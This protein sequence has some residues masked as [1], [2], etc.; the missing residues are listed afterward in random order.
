MSAGTRPA[1]ERLEGRTLFATAVMLDD[2]LTVTG[3][4]R[5]ANM[6]TV[7][8]SA[9]GTSVEV[10]IDLTSRRGVTRSFEA[11]FPLTVGIGS[12]VILG[13]VRADSITIDETNSPFTLAVRADGRLGADTILGGSGNDTLRGGPGA[14]TLEGRGGNDALHGGLGRDTQR[15][16]DGDDAVWGGLG[17]DTING[18]PGNDRLGGILGNNVL[19]GAGGA[20]EFLVRAIEHNPDNDY[21]S[22]EDVLTIRVTAEDL[23]PSV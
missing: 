20:D 4:A 13:G 1:V 21:D 11:A 6:I 19:I 10:K 18:G 22:T 16:G 9:D 17:R 15:G 12:V 2:V 23:E 5:A 7:A 14:D 8:N 3:D